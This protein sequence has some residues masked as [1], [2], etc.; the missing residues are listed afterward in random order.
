MK[1]RVVEF[2]AHASPV[3][4]IRQLA[5]DCLATIGCKDCVKVCSLQPN[6]LITG[7]YQ[8]TCTF[9]ISLEPYLGFCNIDNFISERSNLIAVPADKSV[10]EIWNSSEKSLCN[11][12]CLGDPE[13]TRNVMYL[14]C[15]K[16]WEDHKLLT[17]YENGLI[18]IWDL[19]SGETDSKMKLDLTPMCVEYEPLQSKGIVGGPEQT[20]I[21]FSVSAEREKVH[22]S[23][24]K[25]VSVT[26][27][28][29][30]KLDSILN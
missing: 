14:K 25:E 15:L 8:L 10:V 12:L 27:D 20:F 26:N 11:S 17:A 19:N 23:V 29:E 6:K 3:T 5:A 7:S 9:T 13:N 24:V 18:A 22:L 4:A 21:V 28:G 2:D 16:H 1:A 30:L